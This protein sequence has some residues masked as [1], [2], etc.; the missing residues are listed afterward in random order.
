MA[1]ES[2]FVRDWCYW[3]NHEAES[4][5]QLQVACQMGPALAKWKRPNAGDGR[6]GLAQYSG[7]AAVNA[8]AAAFE[9]NGSEFS[10]HLLYLFFI[11][12]GVLDPVVH[13]VFWFGW[14][15]DQ[16]I[17]STGLG[18]RGLEV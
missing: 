4:C 15:D 9:A 6:A 8:L 5:T 13:L 2:S 1:H 10:V 14:V 16:S 11:I 17:F 18:C 3:E 12:L 7:D